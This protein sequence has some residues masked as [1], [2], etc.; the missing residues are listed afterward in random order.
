MRIARLAAAMATLLPALAW[1]QP[2][3]STTPKLAL[4][5]VDQLEAARR[6]VRAGDPALRPAYEALLRDAKAAMTAGP[7]AVTDKRIV[8]PSGDKRDYLSFGPYWWPDSTKPN[9]MP[10]IRRDGIV[11]PESRASSDSP[12]LYA[13]T[14]AVETLA[15][16]H[17]F[18]GD[19]ATRR[20]RSARACCCAASSSTRRPRCARTRASGRRS[21][22]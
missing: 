14:D 19:P 9:G 7:W 12:R 20:T 8:P 22:A 21:R 17:W 18:T 4:L 11:N 13:L 1:A 3:A 15:L 16:A 2:K 10:Y 5:R 6:R